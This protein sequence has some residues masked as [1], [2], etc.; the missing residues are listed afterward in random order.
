LGHASFW[1]VQFVLLWNICVQFLWRCKFSLLFGIYLGV[2]SLTSM[3]TPVLIFWGTARV[4]QSSHFIL[5][6]HQMYAMVLIPLHHHQHLLLSVFLII[7]ILTVIFIS[8]KVNTVVRV[9]FSSDLTSEYKLWCV[10]FELN[11]ICAGVW[12][13]LKTP[14]T[15]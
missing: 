10:F 11:H 7:T 12:H 4:F 3:V 13:F 6:S 5:H 8:L 15:L 1:V 2:E 14:F 9:F